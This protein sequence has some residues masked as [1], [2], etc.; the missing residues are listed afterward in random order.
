AF[1]AGLLLL[2][3]A[4]LG[5]WLLRPTGTPEKPAT[6]KTAPLA[7][8]VPKGTYEETIL[9]TLRASGYP[10]LEGKWHYIGP[11]DNTGKKGF[12]AVYPPEQGIDLQQSYA[13]K[14]NKPVQW[15]ALPNFRLGEIYDIKQVLN[16]DWAVVYFY[17]EMEARDQLLLDLSFGSDDTLSVWLN[18]QSLLASNIY[19]GAAPD[20]DIVNLYLKPGKNQ[21][22]VKVCQGE[23]DWAFYVM[24]RWPNALKSAF[25]ASL[26]RDFPKRKN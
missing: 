14:D 20:Q 13:G 8:Y 7:T 16:Y 6:T 9:A 2:G 11:F 24:P 18:G 10:S 1:A 21:L 22:L 5:A 3:L 23:S 25:G 15:K 17:H 26:H 19:R 12:D 4:T